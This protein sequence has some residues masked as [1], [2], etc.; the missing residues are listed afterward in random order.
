MSPSGKETQP[1][2]AQRA[3]RRFPDSIAPQFGPGGTVLA[4]HTWD[5]QFASREDV[6]AG[7]EDRS[8]S[9]DRDFWSCGGS[10]AHWDGTVVLATALDGVDLRLFRFAPGASAVAVT[11]P[12]GGSV[13]AFATAGGRTVVAWSTPEKPSELYRLGPGGALTQITHIN[14]LPAGLSVAPT[15]SA[16]WPV[17]SGPRACCM[18][19]TVQPRAQALLTE[20]HGVRQCV[21]DFRRSTCNTSRR[22]ATRFRPSVRGSDGYGDW[23]YKAIVGDFGAGPL[24]DLL[25]GAAVAAAAVVT[26]ADT[27]YIYGART[28]DTATAL[29]HGARFRAAVAAFPVTDLA[30]DLRVVGE[31][32]RHAAAL[33]RRAGRRRGRTYKMFEQSPLNVAQDM[34]TPLLLIAGV[35]DARA[36]YAQT[37]AFYRRLSELGKPVRLL[38]Y[39]REG[40]GPA[41]RAQ[42]DYTHI[43]G[44]PAA[45][46]GACAALGGARWRQADDDGA[47]PARRP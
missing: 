15:T 1:R 32:G 47:R 33:L 7:A 45:H 19:P 28:A 46:G 31:S 34:N 38:V 30:L 26:P 20:P 18:L 10:Q 14:R 16:A 8:A 22:T 3:R 43:A 2:G 42:D 29:T 36:P 23:S 6:Y 5:G 17:L 37:V 27:S 24:T 11:P 13:D 41:R 39:P 21:D 25:A 9:L 44:W 12:P 4:V 40:H 35:Q